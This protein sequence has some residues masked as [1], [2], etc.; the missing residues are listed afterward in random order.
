VSSIDNRI[1]SMKFDNAQ[2]ERGVSTTIS[3]MDKLKA[4]LNFKD[5]HKS[6]EGL[7]SAGKTFSMGNM[8]G[9]VTGVSKAFIALSTIGITT[10]SRITDKAISTGVQLVKSLTIDPISS[11]LKEYE[12]NLGAI[13]TILSNTQAEGTNLKD[14][15]KA[16]NELNTYSD[17]TIYNFSEMARNIGTFTAAGVKLKP[18]VQAIKGIANLAAIS[19]SNSEQASTAMYQLSQALSTGR[20]ALQDWNSVVNA[21]MGGK[22]FQEALKRTARNHGVAVDSIIAKQGSFRESL[23]KGWLTSKVLTETLAQ[24]TGDLSDK[25]LKSMGYTTEQIKAIQ[26]QAKLAKD[27]ATKVKT[28]TQL[29]DTLRE[30][31]GSGWAQT[32]SLIFGDF[33]EAKDLFTGLNNTIGGW[34]SASADARNKVLGDWKKLGGRTHLIAGIKNIFVALGRVLG[35]IK[36]AFRDIFPPMTGKRLYDLTI[37]FENFTKKLK[38]S[39][40][41]VNNLKRTFK[42]IFAVFSILRSLAHGV[43]KVILGVFDALSGPGGDAGGGFLRVTANIGD[44]L[45]SIDEMLKKTKIIDK[46]F[47]GIGASIAFVIKLFWDLARAVVGV[48]TG[49]QTNLMSGVSEQFKNLAPIIE[50]IK[51]KIKTITDTVQ[52]FFSAFKIPPDLFG[53]S[54]AMDNTAK[55]VENL[56]QSVTDTTSVFTNLKRIATQIGAA[57]SG[58]FS[59]IGAQ[60]SKLTEGMNMEDWLAI[61][62]TGFF[63]SLFKLIRG[64]GKQYGALIENYATAIEHLGNVF[65]GFGG[66]MKGMQQNL[67]ADALMKI[68]IAL[69]ILVGAIWLLSLLDPKDVATGL[70]ALAVMLGILNVA[71]KMLGKGMSNKGIARLGALS[72]VLIV[73]AAAMIAMAGAVLAFG[74]MKPETLA[75]GFASI[76]AVL[77]IMIGAVAA[78]EKVGGAK[79]IVVAAGGLLVMAIALTS[80][81]G[82]V[83][84]FSKIDFGTIASGLIKMALVLG[85]LATFM[86]LIS[87]LKIGSLIGLIGAAIALGILTDVIKRM[88]DIPFGTA[89]KGLIVMALAL[90]IVAIALNA[91]EATLPG[92]AALLVAVLAMKLL[93]PVLEALG[94]M[95]WGAILKGLVAIAAAFAV[96]AIGGWLLAPVIPIIALFAASVLLVGIAMFAAGAGMLAFAT[97]LG[98]L[99]VVGAAGFAVLTSAIITFIEL[100]PLIGEQLGLA[101]VAWAKVI[102]DKA[103]QLVAALGKLM[104]ALLKEIKKRAPEFY[105]TMIDLL[106]SMI[107]AITKKLPDFVKAVLDLVDAFVETLGSKETIKHLYTAAADLIINFLNGLAEAIDEK[108]EELG[109]A[110]GKIAVAIG[111]GIVKGIGGFASEV[112]GAAAGLGDKAIDSLKGVLGIHSP[113]KE[114]EKIGREVARGLALGIKVNTIAATDASE[115]MGLA[116]VTAIKNVVDK[117]RLAMD[118]NIDTQPVIAP[119]LDLTEFRKKA[120]EMSQFMDKTPLANVTFDQASAIAATRTPIPQDV[121]DQAAKKDIEFIQNNYSPK[122]LSPAEIY[123]NTRN[124]L[125]FAKE[126]IAG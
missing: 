57:I 111:K 121:I 22:V 107:K 71:V 52:H 92:A 27:A 125:I 17:Q 35:P 59:W 40:D 82:V 110:G 67:K 98:I 72:A 99:A 31:A 64:I 16:L 38:I 118:S 7:S 74:K 30:T 49:N 51:E 114:F 45:S 63:I 123:R 70:G 8:E 78:L 24:F 124:Q 103:P 113:S 95:S 20:V 102:G 56:E 104:S 26:K 80:L 68:A 108:S 14:V 83:L 117:A 126:L 46:F 53:A 36:D 105:E 39:D 87:G 77:V 33:E 101:F 29:I 37:S 50:L 96:V 48:F 120:F 12:T 65:K 85:V 84:L 23:K 94:K 41:T 112:A 109:R 116:S 122:A 86:W 60:I 79:N 62:N 13:Q 76:I 54:T 32:W 119:V 21:G 34:I 58:V 28:A 11:G 25:Q 75:K 73:F 44:F 55:S 2:F 6:L 88:G 66:V 15:N 90:T 61:I 10:L 93:V 47:S 106:L 1:V 97:G 69:L 9:A 18:S 42:G 3:S 89:A 43:I 100:L 115:D 5:A 81:A 4:S 19:G 91:M